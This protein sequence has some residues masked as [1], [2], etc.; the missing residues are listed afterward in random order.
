MSST[1]SSFRDS[2]VSAEVSPKRP[3]LNERGLMKK[4][5]IYLQTTKFRTD[6]SE[7]EGRYVV[8]IKQQSFITLKEDMSIIK[9]LRALAEPE[10]GMWDVRDMSSDDGWS[11]GELSRFNR[12]TQFSGNR[13]LKD[14]WALLSWNT[15]MASA[16]SW[17]CDSPNYLSS[18]T[19]R[20]TLFT[21]RSVIQTS[22]LVY[23]YSPWT[24]NHNSLRV[25]M[26][27]RWRP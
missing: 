22:G 15:A 2:W 7:W 27:R 11:R 20:I 10:F 5:H 1:K 24:R 16:M 3:R 26:A 17:A 14:L 19:R 4:M 25:R 18:W 6:P 21:S 13:D 23:L 8:P 9:G 12:S